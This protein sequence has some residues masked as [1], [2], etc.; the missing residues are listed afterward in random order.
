MIFCMALL[1]LPPTFFSRFKHN[2]EIPK[3]IEELLTELEKSGSL[4]ENNAIK[5]S[6]VLNL[7]TGEKGY[8]ISLSHGMSS[9]IAFLIRLH[10]LNFKVERVEKLLTRTINYILQQIN[11]KEG[12]A[13]YFPSYSK[14]NNLGNPDSRLG[15]CYGDLGIA[16][17]LFRVAI[18]LSNKELEKTA[19]N[20]LYHN[21]SRLD[22]KSN[23]IQDASLCHGTAGVALIFWKIYLNT[24]INKFNE[25]GNYWIN[26]TIQMAKYSDGLAGFK[27]WQ[28][29]K[30]G[31]FVSSSDLLNGISGI[32]LIL[33]TRLT[34]KNSFGMNALCYLKNK[35]NMFNYTYLLTSKI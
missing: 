3:Y 17:M 20:I 35:L 19:I 25:T 33:L 15:W 10:Q 6:S 4:C 29:K 26:Q 23:G 13:S 28:T 1:G 2:K 27:A 5:W 31:G 22:L 7:E 11:Y 21:C 8:N 9:I 32:G 30:F 24:S 12:K 14:E 34:K 18:L 16:Y